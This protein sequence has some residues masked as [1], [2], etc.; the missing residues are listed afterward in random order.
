[1]FL[2]DAIGFIIV[3]FSYKSFAP[4]TESHN[5]RDVTSAIKENRVPS[6][7][8]V[9]LLS[10]FIFM[11]VDRVIYLRR[12]VFGKL[13]L[14]VMLVI[15]AHV[16][17]FF[18]LPSVTNRPF[19]KNVTAQLW[20]FFK[21]LYFGLS[22]YQ[23]RCRYP[24]RILGN[25]LTKKYN[26][27][28]LFFFKIFQ[29]TPFMLEI[30][31]LMD[32]MWTD[33]ALGLYSWVQ[34]EDIYN[35]V[36]I[37][38]C[39]LAGEDRYV[40]ARATKRSP[41]I[42]YGLGGILLFLLFLIIWFPMLL[43]SF[44]GTV[45][46]SKAPLGCRLSIKLDSYKTVFE[47]D[48][49]QHQL[50]EINSRDYKSLR[51][52]FIANQSATAFLSMYTI[53]DVYIADINGKAAT[54]WA[55]TP[56]NTRGL[57]NHLM[58]NKTFIIYVTV[59]IP[60]ST[61]SEPYVYNFHYN[62][63]STAESRRS[64]E[65]LAQMIMPSSYNFSTQVLPSRAVSIPNI[66]P[67]YLY[68]SVKGVKQLTNLGRD[69][70]N[71]MLHINHIDNSSAWW[72]VNEYRK[73]NTFEPVG[74]RNKYTWNSTIRIVTFNER[75][76]P[77][78]LATVTSYGVVGLYVSIVFMVGKLVRMMT[79][80]LSHSVIYTEMPYVGRI[81]RLCQDIYLVRENGDMALEEELFAKLIFLYRSP[82]TLI[83]ITRPKVE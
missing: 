17:M 65:K 72:Q 20:Y 62:L 25:F 3:S 13:I 50:Y 74:V 63:T 64:R 18:I 81:M 57:Y 75:V 14:Q 29:I 70:I 43:F 49:Q 67:R 40:T 10:L 73:R 69:Y 35:N 7:F 78:I 24:A 68:V 26:Y 12:L 58:G 34:M 1:M 53:S 21:C 55:S 36:F 52:Q 47:M 15:G 60:S 31:Y 32:W 22:A 54:L 11:L 42:K 5:I 46:V 16:W 56:P 76:A 82:E 39:F 2:C 61:S 77:S 37:V 27:T 28:N 44:G 66:L 33:T 9:M 80:D 8:L 83:K 51:Q 41:I 59:S 19:S 30:R 4:V 23:I 79:G 6:A 48:V 45:F 38:A 71:L